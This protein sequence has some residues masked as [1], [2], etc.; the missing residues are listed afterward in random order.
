MVIADSG[1]SDGTCEILQQL[2]KKFDKIRILSETGKFHGEKLM[3]LY[4]YAIINGADYVF[5][6]DSDGQTNPDEFPAFWKGERSMTGYLA[7]D[8]CVETGRL[9][10]SLSMSSVFC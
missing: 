7:T 9:G 2:S 1:S 6:T 10:L 5:Q 4:D 3:A 8:K